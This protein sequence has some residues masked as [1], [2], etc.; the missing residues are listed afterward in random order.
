MKVERVFVKRYPRTAVNLTEEGR[1]A[2]ER[3]KTDLKGFLKEFE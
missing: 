3:Y 1:R 2:Y